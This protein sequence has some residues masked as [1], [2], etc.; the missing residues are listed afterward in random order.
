MAV[1]SMPALALALVFALA[2]ALPL[3]LAAAVA[4]LSGV[5]SPGALR[6]RELVTRFAWVAVLPAGAAALAGDGERHEIEWMLLGTSIRL[7]GIARPLVLMAVV[8][9][10]LALSFVVRSKAERGHVLTAFLLLCFAGNIAVF[11]ADDLVTFYL[12]FAAMS[13]L[14]YAIVVHDRTRSARRAG[15][16]YLV[17]TV[18]GECAVLA[19]LMLLAAD[20]VTSVGEAPAA[21]AASPASGAIILL[22]LVGFGVKAGTV[23][24]HVWLPLAHPAAPSPASAVLSGAMLKA[25]IVGWL[26]F[27]P[28]GQADAAGGGEPVW[29]AVFLV[30]GLAGGLLAVPAGVLQRN[31][32]VILAYSS[33]SQ[34]GFITAIIGAALVAPELAPACV[35]AV[36]VYSVSHGLVKG[37]LFLGVQAWDSEQM[38][39]R[40]VVVPLAVASLAL[41][42]VPFTSGYVA[43]YA[44]KEAVGDVLA[45]LLPGV[46]VADV[47]PWFGVGSTLLLARFAVALSRRERKPR[48]T[49][50]TRDVAWSVLAVAAVGP[51]GALAAGWAPPLSLPG[52]LDPSAMWAQ[53]WPLLVGL[54]VAAVAVIV[55]RGRPERTPTVPPGDIVV[56]EERAAR[57]LLRGLTVASN[58]LGRA[59][60]AIVARVA[61]G[62]DAGPGLDA[63]QRAVGTWVGSGVVLVVVLAAALVAAVAASAGAGT[64]GTG[65]AL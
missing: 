20:G 14:G 8:L 37:A 10:G 59:R 1:T 2:F 5:G 54:A 39:R 22:L 44:G 46:A 51:V 64:V 7:D 11:V 49:A 38:P 31:P 24:L 62:P 43:K 32:K 63:A 16:I 35:A 50:R 4:V 26:R 55:T 33:I 25:G 34:M 45:P 9:Y 12:A 21:V 36:V 58:A 3:A 17:L 48:P 42:G 53:S 28:L 61:A 29:G 18:F 52:W 60:D 57:G 47:L 65:G 6:L 56:I 19:A 30:L 13:F 23:P 27:L 40:A 15:A 41:V